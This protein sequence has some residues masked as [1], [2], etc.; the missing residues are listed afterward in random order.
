MRNYITYAPELIIITLLL[1][2]IS[3]Y[4]QSLALFSFTSIILFASLYF[5][6]GACVVIDPAKDILTSPCEGTIIHIGREADSLR[7]ST[8]L[9]VHNRHVQYFP[10]DGTI[11]DI[12]HKPGEFNPAYFFEKSMFNERTETTI[13]T[14]V[15]PV[16]IIQIAGQI[17]RRICGFHQR[18]AYV[19]K[20]EPL[21]LIKFGSRVDVIVPYVKVKEIFVKENDKITIGQSLLRLI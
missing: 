19:G 11:T 18:G 6:R 15:G 8:F 9:N 5:Y 1:F 7:I 2:A 4:Y 21:G 10:L 13:M 16:K 3:F 12:V 20:G 14:H 17:A